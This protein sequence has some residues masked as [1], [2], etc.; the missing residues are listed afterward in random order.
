[1]SESVINSLNLCSDESYCLYLTFDTFK[2]A[3]Y[4]SKTYEIVW[5]AISCPAE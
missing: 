3:L 5:E 4:S 1:M 2:R